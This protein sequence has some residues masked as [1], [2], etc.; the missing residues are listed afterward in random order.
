MECI[1]KLGVALDRLNH[2]RK[3]Q[4]RKFELKE[5]FRNN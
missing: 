3:F 2:S 5:T 4:E 1:E